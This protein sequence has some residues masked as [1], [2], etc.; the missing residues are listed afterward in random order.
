MQS[1]MLNS[2]Y[3]MSYSILGFIGAHRFGASFYRCLGPR[4]VSVG[5][6]DF[7][8]PFLGLI[9]FGVTLSIN[10]NNSSFRVTYTLGFPLEELT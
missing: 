1:V 3:R 6:P 2:I 7:G 9:Y 4:Q 5:M 8:A 10:A